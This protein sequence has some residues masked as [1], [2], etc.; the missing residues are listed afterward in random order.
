MEGELSYWT[1][2]RR[3][4]Q[5][6]SVHLECLHE[7]RVEQDVQRPA[8]TGST[9]FD[10]QH[11]ENSTVNEINHKVGP[12][13]EES[14]RFQEGVSLNEQNHYD[15]P[16]QQPCS[17][18]S[19]T[20]VT[21]SGSKTSGHDDY[22]MSSR[23]IAWAVDF[24]IPHSAINSLMEILGKYHPGLPKDARTL[25]NTPRYCDIKQVAGGSYH[26]FGVETSLVRV[27]SHKTLTT[28]TLKDEHISLQINVDGLPLFKS[29]NSQFWPILARVSQPVESEPF[30][31]ALYCG[32][33][34]PR[35]I[36]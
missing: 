7:A 1:K 4:K 13:C 31:I 33:H 17:S 20:D 23:L 3:I 22:L 28:K 6:V 8:Q 21:D 12:D 36:S 26:Y 5:Q 15:L 29:S 35:N 11:T 14:E 10:S 34:K 19:D 32:S 30:I 27:L 16:F 18:G 2:R 24:K 25:L 9:G